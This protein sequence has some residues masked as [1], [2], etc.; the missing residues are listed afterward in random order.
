MLQGA[1]SLLSALAVGAAHADGEGHGHHAPALC[2]QSQQTAAA[3]SM[4]LA[5]LLLQRQVA[6]RGGWAMCQQPDA[7]RNGSSSNDC[8]DGRRLASA[9]IVRRKV[10]SAGLTRPAYVLPSISAAWAAST[11]TVR[12]T[13]ARSHAIVGGAQGGG[14][15]VT[16]HALLTKDFSGTGVGADDMKAELIPLMSSWHKGPVGSLPR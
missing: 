2:V 7:A 5:E 6:A 9:I 15:A 16:S 3:A 1:S 14:S 8:A 10:R 11:V 13:A 4:C 12:P